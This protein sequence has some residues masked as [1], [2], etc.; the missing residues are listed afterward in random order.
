MVASEIY[1]RDQ[2]GAEMLA[3]LLDHQGVVQ[4]GLLEGFQVLQYVLHVSDGGLELGPRYRFDG[5]KCY[6]MSGKTF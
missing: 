6:K 1:K 4:Q 2:R 5:E 3:L